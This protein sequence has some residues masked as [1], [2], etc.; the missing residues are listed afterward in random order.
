MSGR[1]LDISWAAENVP[2]I[3]EVWYPGSEGG[4]AVADLL[5]GDASPGGKLPVTWMRHVGQIPIYY[6]HNLTQNPSQQERRY[7]NEKAVPLYPFGYGLSYTTFAVS[8][9]KLSQPE[10]KIGAATDVSVEVKNTGSRAGDEVVQLYI[11]QQAGGASR[12]IR[13]L[14][15]F[16]RVTLAPGETK[17]ARFKLGPQELRYW[18]AAVRDWVQEAETFD[19]WAGNDSTASLHAT[20]K[21]RP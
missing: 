10:I 8:N 18:N 5:F 3:L 6:S 9:L 16:E 7:W 13:E 21:V 12:P 1:P 19:V 17:I 4:N 15:G 11:H 2:S 14:K 20:L